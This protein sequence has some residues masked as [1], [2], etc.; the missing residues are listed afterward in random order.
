MRISPLLCPLLKWCQY[1][2]ARLRFLSPG[3]SFEV[4]DISFNLR[5]DDSSLPKDSDFSKWA[6]FMLQASI[7][8]GAPLDS[9]ESVKAL[10]IEIGFV[11]VEQRIYS[12]PQNS[13]PADSRHK[14]IGESVKY[15]AFLSGID[16]TGKQ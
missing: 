5:C 14:L 11:D 4:Q 6:A 12:W 1:S 16:L 7:N 8:L 13:W 3:G 10:M 9:V 15:H 2:H